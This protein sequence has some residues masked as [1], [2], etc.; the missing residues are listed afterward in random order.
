MPAVDNTRTIAITKQMRWKSCWGSGEVDLDGDMMT[1]TSGLLRRA[2]TVSL[3]SSKLSLARWSYD[4]RYVMGSVLVIED[5]ST[6]FTIATAFSVRGMRYEGMESKT[7]VILDPDGFRALMAAIGPR[8]ET[9]RDDDRSASFVLQST[10]PFAWMLAILAMPGMIVGALTM[11]SIEHAA[12]RPHM[13]VIS[14]VLVVGLLL[15]IR[16]CYRRS[17]P[18]ELRVDGDTVTMAGKPVAKSS[19][20]VRVGHVHVASRFARADMPAIELMIGKRRLIVQSNEAAKHD[21]GPRLSLSTHMLPGDRFD[22]IKR[23]VTRKSA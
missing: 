14:L 16:G 9:E 23:M 18:L 8:L 5:R 11:A 15:V 12:A 10:R 19:V 1:M 2:R 4:G 20:R 3:A 21:L 17:R 7:D 22:H 6:R 13:V